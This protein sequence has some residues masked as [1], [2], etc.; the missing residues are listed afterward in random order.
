MWY[1]CFIQLVDCF[2]ARFS[3][4]AQLDLRP[5]T[6]IEGL[7]LTGQDVLTCGFSSSLTT[8]LFAASAALKQNLFFALQ[9]AM[10]KSK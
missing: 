4:S 5:D 3:P 8:G 10:K 1:C 7:F 2:S 9:E 6:P